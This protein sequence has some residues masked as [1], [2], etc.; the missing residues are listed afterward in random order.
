MR[1]KETSA[2]L[3]LWS[4]GVP[5]AEGWWPKGASEAENSPGKPRAENQY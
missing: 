5:R 4:K 1:K 3:P 2:K